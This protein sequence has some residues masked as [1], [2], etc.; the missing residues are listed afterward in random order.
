MSTAFLGNR[1]TWLAAGAWGTAKR[2]KNRQPDVPRN[3]TVKALEVQAQS[4]DPGKVF[5]QVHEAMRS[6]TL[7][8]EQKHAVIENAHRVMEQQMDK[9]LDE[10]FAAHEAQRVT[11]LDKQL[12]KFKAREKEWEQRRAEHEKERAARGPAVRPQGGAPAGGPD[13]PAAGPAAAG[14]PNPP[15]GHW[16]DLTA[17]RPN[18]SGNNGLR[19]AAPIG[20]LVGWR[21]GRPSRRE[22][23]S[24]VSSCAVRGA[25][26]RDGEMGTGQAGAW[27]CRSSQSPV[28]QG[29]PRTCINGS[30]RLGD[31][32]GSGNQGGFL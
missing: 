29:G 4:G 24:A 19:T 27:E 10:Y 30:Q 20:W 8:D 18:R 26:D 32:M 11:I 2:T 23:S 3:L 9:R 22:R 17:R 5:H 1:K 6:D 31:A 12:D 14:T 28:S 25:A 7:T 15:P 13:G 16:G 21:I